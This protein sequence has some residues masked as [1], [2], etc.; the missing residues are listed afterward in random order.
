MYEAHI[1]YEKGVY[2][3]GDGAALGAVQSEPYGVLPG[4]RADKAV[5]VAKHCFVEVLPTRARIARLG[6]PEGDIAVGVHYPVG[7]VAPDFL[8]YL[9]DY[10][11]PAHIVAGVGKLF[12][13][14]IAEEECAVIEEGVIFYELRVYLV[15]RV[16]HPAQD[17]VDALFC[18]EHH[19]GF[20]LHYLDGNL[21]GRPGRVGIVYPYREPA[22]FV[23][24][25]I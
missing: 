11:L 4:L 25:G 17:P 24:S 1:R 13:G 6:E 5:I 22:R 19:Y 3:Y 15:A 7:G 2:I 12:L 14:D 21:D 8:G 20:S 18:E 16:I 23:E 10:K 9:A